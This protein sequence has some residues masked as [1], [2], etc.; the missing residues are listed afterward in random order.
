MT[1]IYHDWRDLPFREIWAI[2]FEYYPGRGKSHGGRDGDRITPLCLVAHEMRS[3]R[4]IRLWQDEL[5]RFPPYRL[6]ADAMILSCMLS[7]DFSAHLAM[8]WA[9]RRERSIP[10]S[11]FAIS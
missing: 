2:D 10:I 7:A 9:S 3:G 4:T 11:S 8:G 1:T 6:D 5:G